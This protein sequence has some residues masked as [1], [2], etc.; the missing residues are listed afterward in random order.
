M[1]ASATKLDKNSKH[2]LTVGLLTLVLGF[3][4]AYAIP[5]VGSTSSLNL[6]TAISIVIG[7]MLG[8]VATAHSKFAN[9]LVNAIVSASVATL[10]TSMLY[11]AFGQQ[12]SAVVGMVFV[13][14]FLATFVSKKLYK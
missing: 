7:A 2:V 13:G 9:P 5:G 11:G 3:I 12:F 14:S 6:M 10:V 4:A 1:Q 8:A